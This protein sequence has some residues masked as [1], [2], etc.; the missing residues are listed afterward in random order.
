MTKQQQII[1]IAGVAVLVLGAGAVI[2]LRPKA[3]EEDTTVP[4]V[5]QKPKTGTPGGT[6]AAGFPGPPQ[7][8]VKTDDK[9]ATG[10]KP[11]TKTAEGQP[12]AGPKSGVKTAAAGKN[13]NPKAGNPTVAQKGAP[14]GNGTPAPGQ[15]SGGIFGNN[16]GKITPTQVP[17]GGAG[18]GGAGPT[19]NGSKMPRLVAM[20]GY[21]KDPFYIDWRLPVPPPDVFGM[22]EPVR[23]P[24]PEVPTRE[25]KP[26]EI[27]EQPQLRVSGIMS[28]EGVFAILEKADNQVDIVKP[29]SEVKIN[30]DGQTQRTYRV[31]SI[32]GDTVKLESKVGNVTY[33]QVVPLSDVPV[34]VQQ[35]SYQG[36]G[37]RPG[38]GGPGNFGPGGGNYP[39]PGGGPGPGGL[40]GGKRGGGIPGGGLGGGN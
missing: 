28:G 33:K 32:N 34:G 29:G 6:P 25:T 16:G 26:I 27:R 24:G 10:Q 12:P 23:I 36:G 18:A 13:A 31:V 19:A 1:A 21:R 38:F 20:G 2:L 11:D 17:G 14:G 8:G 40:P 4:A 5:G 39:G 22:V 35:T 15:G 7:K 37:G 9:M 30:V 3:A